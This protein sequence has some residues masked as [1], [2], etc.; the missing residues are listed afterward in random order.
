MSPG[1]N[2]RLSFNNAEEQSPTPDFFGNRPQPSLVMSPGPNRRLSFGRAEED[3]QGPDFF[4]NQPSELEAYEKYQKWPRAM[5][6]QFQKQ[7]DAMAARFMDWFQDGIDLWTRYSGIEAPGHAAHHVNSAIGPQYDDA[8]Q[9]RVMT[10]GFRVVSS[11]DSDKRVR[12]LH[13]ACGHACHVFGSLESCLT[14]KCLSD[15]LQWNDPM[16]E[17][18]QDYES[19]GSFLNLVKRILEDVSKETTAYCHVHDML[20]PV[21]SSRTDEG[22]AETSKKLSF[23]VAGP[24]CTDWSR[25]GKKA[26]LAGAENATALAVW[27]AQILRSNM[28]V[29]IHEATVGTR[30]DLLSGPLLHFSETPGAQAFA[31]EQFQLNPADCGFPAHRPPLYTVMYRTDLYVFTGSQEHFAG[32]L[33]SAFADVTANAG[34]CFQRDMNFDVVEVE[35]LAPSKLQALENYMK[36]KEAKDKS[37]MASLWNSP[38]AIWSSGHRMAVCIRVLSQLC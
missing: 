19:M 4:G 18:K 16:A 11:G 17:S 27:F 24:T 35:S 13:M 5:M 3:S 34:I 32:L 8:Q 12:D 21:F 14:S 20:C 28:D 22:E 31:T 6:E 25:R 9:P 36:I 37:A 29:G 30:V 38:S 7:D 15:L 1:L 23:H 10:P 26:G 2:L 33:K